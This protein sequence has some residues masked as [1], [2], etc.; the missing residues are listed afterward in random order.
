MR[1]IKSVAQTY[2]VSE[3]LL[4]LLDGFR[5]MVNACVDIGLITGVTSLKSLSVVA[6]P[7]LASF[8]IPSYYK[9]CAI[10]HAT[11][12]LRN[13]RKSLRRNPKTRRPYSRRLTLR[14]CYGFK[15]IHGALRLP[16]KPRV[17]ANIPL[18]SHTVNVLSEPHLTVRSVSFTASKLNITFSKDTIEMEPAGLVGL[19][20]NLNNI[21]TVSTDGS[22]VRYNLSRAT[23]IGSKYRF[24]RSRYR[25]NDFRIKRRIY[26]KYGLK[27]RNKTLQLVHHVSKEIVQ[28]ARAQKLGSGPMPQGLPGLPR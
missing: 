22:I 17:H 21:T 4:R 10:S 8:N 9:L 27:Q 20:R 12:I 6:Y 19:D 26:A 11:G 24:V 23:D 14:T 3:D 2:T 28:N 16:I 18:N 25:R 7:R 1:A 13:Y 5:M 15:I